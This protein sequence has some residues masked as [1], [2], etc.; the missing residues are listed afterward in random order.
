[1]LAGDSPPENPPTIVRSMRDIW[2]KLAV[3]GVPP[4]VT[5]IDDASCWKKPAFLCL[6][7]VKF[8]CVPYKSDYPVDIYELDRTEVSPA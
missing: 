8:P 1:M 5:I 3:F 4:H 6:H 2:L 7:H